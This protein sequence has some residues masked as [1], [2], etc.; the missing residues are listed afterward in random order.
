MSPEKKDQGGQ[1][2]WV[3]TPEKQ[4]E[5]DQ[6]ERARGEKSRAEKIA[7]FERIKAPYFLKEGEKEP[8]VVHFTGKEGSFTRR[9]KVEFG[10]NNEIKVAQ[11]TKGR[12]DWGSNG[13]KKVGDY[14]DWQ[15]RDEVEFAAK[16]L[17]IEIPEDVWF[18]GE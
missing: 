13:I 6:T 8:N 18:K 4:A 5:Q 14:D 12:D 3:L 9:Y 11:E 1:D 10:P 2:P 7:S 17:G 16:T 15:I